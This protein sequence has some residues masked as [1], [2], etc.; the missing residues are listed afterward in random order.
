M[1]QFLKT[2]TLVIIAILAFGGA[3]ANAGTTLQPA[4]NTQGANYVKGQYNTNSGA[5]TSQAA[6]SGVGDAASC[7]GSGYVS[8][9][10]SSAITTIIPS[11][12]TKVGTISGNDKASSG[13]LEVGD[14]PSLDSIA[15]CAINAILTYITQ[16]T[17]NWINSGF[18]GNP[19]FVQDPEKFFSDIADNTAANFLQ[20]VAGQ[21]TGVNICQPFRVGIVTGLGS[22]QAN[23]SSIQG[24]SL[25]QIGNNIQNF[26][27]YTSPGGTGSGGW[28]S[29]LAVTQNP[30][31]N[32][33]GAYMQAQQE[34]QR[35]VSIQGNSAQIDLSTGRGFLSFKKC[36]PDS[37]TT[38]SSGNPVTVK[39]ACEIT[40]PGSVIENTLNNRLNAGTDRLKVA[41]KFDEVVSALVNQLIK[42]ALSDVLNNN[43]TQ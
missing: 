25:S 31:N 3:V 33:M 30:Q 8:S 20:E 6:I 43:S 4:A 39:G 24:C 18:N 41:D 7:I 22:G 29:W 9:L 16:A 10:I 37:T 42:V 27:V 17:V 13:G 2:I 36:N 26:Q 28:G 23:P 32:P 21:V 1:E 14:P 5:A 19:A 34:L 15:Y 35:R 38:D 40:T 12:F 11:S